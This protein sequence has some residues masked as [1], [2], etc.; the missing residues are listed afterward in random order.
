[1]EITYTR[2]RNA[3]RQPTVVTRT[4]S[5]ALRKSEKTAFL[6]HSHADKDLAEGFVKL[7]KQKGWSVYID[8]KDSSLPDK[9]NRATADRIRTKIKACDL[10]IFLAT[11]NSM[12]S[13]WCPWEIGYGD[14][15]RFG[16]NILIVETKDDHGRYHGSE[17][18]QLYRRLTLLNEG[19]FAAF[20]PGADRGTYASAL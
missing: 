12:N 15:A 8:W 18:L 7:A 17:Y 10:F 4:F 19:R 3:Q 9:P 11:H 20:D 6:C 5:E 13:K 14:A 1:M 2:L 16:N